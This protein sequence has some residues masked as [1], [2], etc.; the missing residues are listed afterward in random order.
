MGTHAITPKAEADRVRVL[1]LL[2]RHGWTAT[3]FQILEPGFQYWFDDDACIGYVDTGGAW[4]AAPP[5]GAPERFAD[6][7]QRFAEAA[8]AERR[9]VACFAA[10]QRFV[11]TTAWTSL[12]IGDQPVWQPADWHESLK[13][14]RS[15][16]EQLRRARAKQVT[17]RALT[18]AEVAPGHAMRAELDALIARW[19]ASRPMAPM[20]FLVQVEPFGFAEERRYFVAEHA[21]NVVGFLGVIPL[22]ARRGWFFEDFLRDPAAPNGTIEVLVDAAMRAAI[23]EDIA[24]VTLGLVPLAGEVSPWLAAARWWGKP[25]YDFEGLRAFKAKLRPAA[26]DPIYLAYPPGTHG[27]RALIDALTAFA[28]GG[29]LRFG[30]A[31]ALRSRVIVLGLCLMIVALAA[32]VVFGLAS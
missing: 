13:T 17:V 22:Y 26:W 1:G 27:L 23:A 24:Y 2:Q 25:L 7:T 15:L 30:I 8:R 18:P 6:L 16:R 28:R 12:R 31:T 29:L 10:E 14:T 11:E 20:G 5:V 32:L 3:S 9:R 4:V 19:L 21:G